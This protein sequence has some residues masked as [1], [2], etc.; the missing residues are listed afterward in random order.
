[1]NRTDSWIM[2]PLNK[3]SVGLFKNEDYETKVEV[4]ELANGDNYYSNLEVKNNK[5]ITKLK[6][7]YEHS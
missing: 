5:C 2:N 3:I 4:Y 6:V 7:V 1:M